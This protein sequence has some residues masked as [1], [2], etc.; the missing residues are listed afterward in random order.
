MT[1][2]TIDDSTQRAWLVA[3][4]TLPHRAWEAHCGA[5]LG[6]P[7][8][9]VAVLSNSF[10]FIMAHCEFSHRGHKEHKEQK[11]LEISPAL[12]P[13]PPPLP[14]F[15]AGLVAGG[16]FMANSKTCEIKVKESSGT[17]PLRPYI[18]HVPTRQKHL[19][20]TWTHQLLIQRSPCIVAGPDT[21]GISWLNLTS[22][23][24]NSK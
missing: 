18:P 1:Y 11:D 4:R 22:C 12:P 13:L 24:N 19:G 3:L 23:N 6:L 9:L 17:P 16:G 2:P 10:Q 7:S 5:C 15:S 21:L 8:W 20:H 14:I